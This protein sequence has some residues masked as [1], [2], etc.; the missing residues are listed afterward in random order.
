M[1]NF[2]GV[3]KFAHASGEMCG[4]LSKQMF[5]DTS[6]GNETTAFTK[7]TRVYTQEKYIF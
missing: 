5:A 2:V 7:I 4:H 3:E 1:V 6:V